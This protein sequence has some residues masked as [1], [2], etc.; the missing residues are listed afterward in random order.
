MTVEER[1]REYERIMQDA[2]QSERALVDRLIDE[3]IECERRLE[4]LRG[5][6][7]LAVNP[8]NPAQQRVT[9]AAKL[10]KD[11]AATYTNIIRVLLNILRKIQASAADE[12]ARMLEEFR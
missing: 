4:A 12:L 1:R 10:R 3:A 8:R 6:P 7:D 11:L 5:L 9:A 2:D